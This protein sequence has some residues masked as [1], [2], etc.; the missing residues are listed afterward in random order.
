MI[1]SIIYALKGIINK[2]LKVILVVLQLVI[3]TVLIYFLVSSFD[4]SNAD[5]RYLK[6]MYSSEQLFSI[7]LNNYIDLQKEEKVDDVEEKLVKYIEEDNKVDFLLNNQGICVQINSF[8]GI[9]DFL[10][11]SQKNS[12]SNLLDVCSVMM[13]KAYA[14]F[15]HFDSMML[16]GRNFQDNEYKLEYE[17]RG[18]VPVI[19]GNKYENIYKVGDVIDCNYGVDS[20]SAKNHKL[21]VIGILKK[22]IIIL[23]NTLNTDNLNSV[24]NYII[25]PGEFDDADQKINAGIVHCSKKDFDS[26]L[27]C[28]YASTI[29]A[30]VEC[31]NVK[32][33]LKLD[34]YNKEINEFN[35]VFY[36]IIIVVS[37]LLLIILIV[38]TIKSIKEYSIH[39]LN[40]ATRFQIQS[41]ILVELVM[42]GIISVPISFLLILR[43]ITMLVRM[44]NFI[45]VNYFFITYLILLVYLII[46]SIIPIIIISKINLCKLLG[47]E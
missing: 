5:S 29:G 1:N 40:G 13:N 7:K 9:D 15:L 26:T 35:T 3:S 4:Q 21:E 32:D 43:G 31:S 24:D 19:L 14:D 12:D 22:G 45:Q 6:N 25:V 20:I 47:E 2:P 37:I 34:D 44:P 30:N 28:Q 17:E 33:T 23:D 42:I 18:V 16:E 38:Y 39:I 36:G 10:D 8:N 41:R 46:I 11:F 27:F